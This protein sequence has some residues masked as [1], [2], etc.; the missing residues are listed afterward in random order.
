MRFQAMYAED[1]QPQY[2]GVD[3]DLQIIEDQLQKYYNYLEKGRNNPAYD[4]TKDTLD[5]ISA[6][7]Q[8]N[9]NPNMISLVREMTEV[10]NMLQEHGFP[11]GRAVY[12]GPG[13]EWK[14]FVEQYLD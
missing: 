4:I 9:V 14:R 2:G 3:I 7:I 6:E 13:P 5:A 10:F 11:M 1:Y 12:P 8:N